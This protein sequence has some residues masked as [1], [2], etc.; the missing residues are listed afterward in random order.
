MYKTDGIK[1]LKMKEINFFKIMD[2]KIHP[3]LL[4]GGAKD[5]CI[6]IHIVKDLKKHQKLINDNILKIKN[7][8]SF[9]LIKLML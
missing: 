8:L 5:Q 3:L 6:C 7:N 2:S 9:I 1:C 4:F